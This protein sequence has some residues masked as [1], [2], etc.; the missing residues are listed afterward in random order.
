VYE[1]NVLTEII[2]QI[3]AFWDVISCSLGR[4]TNISGEHIAPLSEQN[5]KPHMEG[6]STDMG[7][8]TAS[9]S[10]YH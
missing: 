8:E 7:K 10:R 2:T 9:A 3:L 1:L 5:V 6:S 4:G